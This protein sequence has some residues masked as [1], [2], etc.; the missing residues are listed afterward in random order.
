MSVQNK[1]V[2]NTIVP[3]NESVFSDWESHDAD[4]AP[5]MFGFRQPFP[6]STPW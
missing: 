1:N 3:I 5:S 2:T 6:K 4:F